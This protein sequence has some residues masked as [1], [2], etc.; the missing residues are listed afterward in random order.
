MK[1]DYNRFLDFANLVSKNKTIFHHGDEY[2]V[3]FDS[4]D[5]RENVVMHGYDDIYF[6]GVFH[7]SGER[8]EIFV[9]SHVA[10]WPEGFKEYFNI[11][12]Q[13]LRDK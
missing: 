6:L 12:N 8:R 9:V 11:V 10:Y 7:G 4:I 1:S 5:C 3:Y 2:I 13:Y